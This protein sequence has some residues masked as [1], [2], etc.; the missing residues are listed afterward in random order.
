M[1]YF[2]TVLSMFL[3]DLLNYYGYLYCCRVRKIC[4]ASFFLLTESQFCKLILFADI[5]LEGMLLLPFTALKKKNNSLGQS[6][7]DMENVHS[8]KS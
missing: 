4:R 6:V 1:A 7:F 8:K 5:G 3:L 2:I